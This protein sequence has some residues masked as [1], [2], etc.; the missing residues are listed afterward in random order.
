MG[1]GSWNK[2]SDVGVKHL[3]VRDQ[4]SGLRVWS[5]GSV[6]LEVEGVNHLKVRDQE[7]GLRVWSRGSVGLEVEG[8]HR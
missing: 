1:T 5:R 3:K 4:E 6:G 7:S 2:G 8:F